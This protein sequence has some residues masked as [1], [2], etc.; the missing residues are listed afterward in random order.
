MSLP[1]SRSRAGFTLVE[2]IIGISLSFM[3]MG[4][5]LSSYLFVARSFTRTLGVSSATQPTLESQGRR[6]LMLFQQDATQAL[7]IKGAPSATSVT[8]EIPTPTGSAEVRYQY[9]QTAQTLSRTT[10][11]VTTVIHINLLD[12]QFTYYD[13]YGRPYSS[14][15]NALSGIDQI[16]LSFS[17]QAGNAANG[18]LSG[19]HRVASSRL[20]LRNRQP[21]S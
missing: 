21:A 12:C 19:I 3:V 15:V 20:T 1:A 7:R 14:F 11:G 5:L 4:A 16:A 2:L 17:A 10:G 9:N 13:R 6:T 8:L 18:T